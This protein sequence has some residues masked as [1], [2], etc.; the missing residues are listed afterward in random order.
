MLNNPCIA[1]LKI[2]FD[3]KEQSEK[4]IKLFLKKLKH[5]NNFSYKMLSEF[6][7]WGNPHDIYSITINNIVGA[8]NLTKIS[9]LIEKC[10]S[11]ET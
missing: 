4:F 3:Y 1:Q 11:N 5:I 10:D 6:D 7:E 2:S 8:N 9:K